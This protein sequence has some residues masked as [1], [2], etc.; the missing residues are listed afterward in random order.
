MEARDIAFLGEYNGYRIRVHPADDMYVNA[1]D[2][3]KACG[4]FWANYWQMQATQ[5]FVAELSGSIGIPIDQLVVGVTKGRNDQRGTWVHRHVAIDFAQWLSP[6]FKVWCIQRLDE[7][8]QTGRVVIH[9]EHQEA[10]LAEVVPLLPKDSH[11]SARQS[12]PADRVSQAEPTS[13]R[14]QSATLEVHAT[15]IASTD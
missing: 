2:M 9:R 13:T 7:L 11:G 1:T 14:L 5:D 3:A 12:Q 6:S 10:A 8:M 15:Y 4:K